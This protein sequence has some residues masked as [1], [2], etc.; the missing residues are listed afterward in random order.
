MDHIKLV[1]PQC[2]LISAVFLVMFT[3]QMYL[4]VRIV[5]PLKQRN[6]SES[7][8]IV[9]VIAVGQPFFCVGCLY[10][11]LTVRM[12]CMCVN[13]LLHIHNLPSSC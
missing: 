10:V 3:A 9:T 4:C 1:E 7:V 11:C 12:F 13:F 2:V 6:V 5:R 8:C